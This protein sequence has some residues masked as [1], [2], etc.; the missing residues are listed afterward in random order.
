VVSHISRKT[1]EIWGTRHLL[2]GEAATNPG[3]V[4]KVTAGPSTTLGMTM[5]GIFFGLRRGLRS[6]AAARLRTE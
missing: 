3:Q 4:N 5:E 6:D 1:S 2:P